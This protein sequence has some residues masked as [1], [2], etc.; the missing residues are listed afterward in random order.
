MAE[1]DD[2]RRNDSVTTGLGIGK[3]K[4]ALLAI[5]ATWDDIDF[6]RDL[7][8]I[9]KGAKQILTETKK[10]KTMHAKRV[11]RIQ[12]KKNPKTLRRKR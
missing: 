5:G 3:L 9:E 6:E 1:K 10:V 12:A 2:D 4:R 7:P 8:R 11:K